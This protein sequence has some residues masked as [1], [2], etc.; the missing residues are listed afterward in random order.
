MRDPELIQAIDKI[1]SFESNRDDITTGLNIKNT[2]CPKKIY[3][4]RAL[5]EFSVNNV[6]NN[7]IWFDNPLK[8]ND[9]YDCRFMWDNSADR[10][11]ISAEQYKS[12]YANA[13]NEFDQELFEYIS[14]NNVSHNEFLKKIKIQGMPAT[15]IVNILNDW[16][17]DSIS[18]FMEGY[19][20][21]IYFCSFSENFSSTLMWAHY[22]KN[23]YGFCI[24]YDSTNVQDPNPFIHQ[25]YPILYTDK[26]FNLNDL[27][28]DNTKRVKNKNFNNLYLNYPLIYKSHEWA[29][30]REWRVIHARGICDKAQN[31][32]TPPISSIFLGSNF[33]K[34][35][36]V[37]ET[38]KDFEYYGERSLAIQLISH[39]MKNNIELKIMKH[40]PTTYSMTA[41]PIS[42]KE[43]FKLLSINI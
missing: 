24:E 7:N 43:C 20:K 21:H 34:P 40:S 16:H 32:Q 19:L 37:E 12:I 6:L 10:N 17:E 35:F 26:L 29:Y 11:F 30:E 28:Y 38:N 39:C 36:N 42:Y 14:N 5:S 27:F 8:M 18:V 3:K 25:L 2:Y 33:F 31:F 23:H 4:Y 15:P 22:S 41:I 9:P 1:F 13:P